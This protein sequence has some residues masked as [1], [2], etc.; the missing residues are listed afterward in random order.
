MKK[1]LL[2]LDIGGIGI[3]CGLVSIEGELIS[4]VEE[5]TEANKG[6]KQILKN[7]KKA[8]DSLLEKNKITTKNII[9]IGV[10][11]PGLPDEKG[12]II[13]G[14]ANLKQ[15]KGTKLGEFLKKEFSLP[16]RIEND[17]TALASG[18]HRFGN[19]KKYKNF[20]SLAF[21][22]G[23]GGGIIIDNKV[24]RGKHGYAAEFGH[25]KVNSE[26][27]APYCTCGK[28]GCLETYASTVGIK[29]MIRE[30][31]KKF[32]T[33]LDLNSMPKDVYALAKEKDKLALLIVKEVGYRLGLGMATLVNIFDPEAIILGGGIIKAGPIFLKSFEYTLYDHILPFYNK[34]KPK[35]LK[36]KLSKEAGIVGSASLILQD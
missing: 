7:I 2:G 36:T 24:Y 1:Y 11:T 12:T 18:E 13:H 8:I 33:K 4:F 5:P 26:P 28:R 22:T 23:L 27:T 19:G 34:H 14:A 29:R 20:I 30:N 31:R 16:V 6:R 9:G 15:W 32:K 35:I 21:G 10:G 25:I 17:V 3:K